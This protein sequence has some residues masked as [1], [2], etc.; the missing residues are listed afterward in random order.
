LTIIVT[1]E[2]RDMVEAL[3]KFVAK[4]VESKKEEEKST[5]EKVT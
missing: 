5:R 4:Y 1:G 2:L 3:T